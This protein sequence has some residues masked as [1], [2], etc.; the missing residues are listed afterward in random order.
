MSGPFLSSSSFRASR[1]FRRV[2]TSFCIEAFSRSS[3]SRAAT[4]ACDFAR[5][6]ATSTT[7]IFPP[8]A[9]GAC[10]AA[11]VATTPA[12]ASIAA[13][14]IVTQYPIRRLL[15]RRAHRGLEC[16]GLFSL[17]SIGVDGIVY[18]N[19][20]ERRDP[21]EAATDPV[22]QIGQIDLRA[23]TV[24]VADVGEGGQPEVERQRDEVLDVAQDL[25]GAAGL[26]AAGVDR[27]QGAE[28]E[29]P[30]RVR[31]AQVEPLEEGHLL[32]LVAENVGRLEVHCEDVVEPDRQKLA[33]GAAELHE[34]G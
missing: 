8:G 18:P 5:M 11:G 25:G 7:T 31:P 23:K 4:P 32:A 20:T 15:D 1:S 21:A 30:E 14:L 24:D 13:I 26:H 6:R 27:R 3:C 2:S 12:R 9:A 28:L 33:R 10:A 29:A 16:P 22:P 19:R 17:S 34:L